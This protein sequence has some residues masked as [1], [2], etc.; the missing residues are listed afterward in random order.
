MCKR[1]VEKSRQKFSVAFPQRL[2]P[3]SPVDAA[4]VFAGRF[5]SSIARA[6]PAIGFV[7]AWIGA[8]YFGA[9][10]IGAACVGGEP[11]AISDVTDQWTEPVGSAGDPTALSATAPPAPTGIHLRSDRIW[12][13]S[14]R[15]MPAIACRA[16]LDPPP[17]QVERLDR[18][19]R[20]RPS[21]VARYL[22]TL[23]PDRPRV[24]YIHGNLRTAPQAIDYGL[25]IYRTLCRG[26]GRCADPAQGRPPIDWVIFSWPADREAFLVRDVRVKAERTDAQGLYLGWLLR[27]H[28]EA[29][30]P[31]ALVGFSFGGRVA[32]GGLHAMAGGPLGGRRLPGP[33]VVGASIDVGLLAPAVQRDWLSTRGMHHLATENLDRMVVCYNSRDL[34]LRHF[35]WIAGTRTSVALGS[36]GPVHVGPRHDG[37]PVPI[38]RL[39]CSTTVGL[40]HSERGYYEKD[41]QASRLIGS[42]LLS[43]RWRD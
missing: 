15:S 32:T 29:C 18:C 19:G 43:S 9:G 31:T 23:S 10:W 25:D 8:A 1:N 5:A 7:A 16:V 22:Q 30:Q 11:I 39:D 35:W 27:H 17:L 13:I 36:T 42:L 14:T 20:R 38:E 6:V 41:S 33:G 21:S 40:N 12:L 37:T 2:F 24:I 34:L 28:A 3:L 4:P 26:C